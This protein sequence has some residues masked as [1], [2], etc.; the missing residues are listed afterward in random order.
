MVYVLARR[1]LKLVYSRRKLHYH[2]AKELEIEEK[3]ERE[4]SSISVVDQ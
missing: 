3:S 4:K 2:R 1:E